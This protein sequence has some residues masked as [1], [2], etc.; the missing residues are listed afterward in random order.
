MAQRGRTATVDWGV[1]HMTNPSVK[2]ATALP[3][4]WELRQLPQWVLWC[5][6]TRAGKPTKVPYA[7]PGRKAAVNNPQSWL[8]YDRAAVAEAGF[9]GLGF[10]LTGTVYCGIDVDHWHRRCRC[11]RRVS[12]G[13]RAA[14]QFI[15]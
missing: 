8:P 7:A 9:D 13:H 14:V 2:P 6:E 5:Y 4:V 15:H 11:G 10:V 1:P 12:S 3:A